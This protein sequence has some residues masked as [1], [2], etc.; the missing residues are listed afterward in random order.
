LASGA[1]EAAAVTCLTARA[2]PP[3]GAAAAAWPEAAAAA[4]AAPGRPSRD[5]NWLPPSAW[6]RPCSEPPAPPAPALAALPPAG[7]VPASASM[8]LPALP[9]PVASTDTV[10]MGWRAGAPRSAGAGLPSMS[11]STETACIAAARPGAAGP[12]ASGG[13]AEAP[14]AARHASP[15]RHMKAWISLMKFCWGPMTEPGRQMRM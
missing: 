5:A 2:A 4:A 6:S 14:R 7:G 12:H 10:N 1:A 15:S 11:P 13:R 8:L 3:R 9:A